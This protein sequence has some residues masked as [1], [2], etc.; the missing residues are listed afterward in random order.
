M[1]EHRQ[2]EDGQIFWNGNLQVV[3]LVTILSAIGLFSV[4]PALPRIVQDL[5][6][7]PQD[8]GL[9]L[10]VFAL[11][12]VFLMPFIG[13]AA[14][15]FGR[16]KV[17]GPALLLFG[18]SG[19]A[20]LLIDDFRAL[21]VL[22]FLQGVAGACLSSLNI[23]IIGDL[24]SGR[25]R[26]TAMGYNQSVFSV[27]ATVLTILGGLLATLGWFYPFMMPLAAVPVWLLV[28]RRLNSPE[29]KRLG[30]LG[31]YL[32]EV[33]AS[34]KRPQVF[35]I[36]VATMVT[37]ILVSGGFYNFFPLLM[38]E[39]FGTSPMIIGVVMSFMMIASAFSSVKMGTLVR[40]FPEKR[41]F[42]ISMLLYAVSLVLMP[43]MPG[44]WYC[45]LPAV[46]MGIAQGMVIPVIQSLLS[47]LS[48]TENRAVVLS[49]YGTSLRVGQTIG[50]VIM[51]GVFSYFGMSGVF[52]FGALLGLAM[53]GWLH[54]VVDKEPM[55]EKEK[56]I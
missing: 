27:G 29:P 56:R 34:L 11:P 21:L 46:V 23:T 45:I 13:M 43:L 49:F 9:V 24:F 38:D 20:C 4:S 28:L 6:V 36:Y 41:L 39:R 54:L 5:S 8:V 12:G 40:Y 44:T 26:T 48:A 51:S 1:A 32:K 14:D 17:L 50:P 35:G 31:V 33:A 16:K 53:I 42:K 52:Y 55:E 18:L 2:E 25:D 10:T 47:G 19:G 15:R 7:A 3:F 30:R 22:R 37:F